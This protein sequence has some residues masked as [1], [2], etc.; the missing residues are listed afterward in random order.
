MHPRGRAHTPHR[1]CVTT[2]TIV[3]ARISV[4][5][6]GNTASFTG[7]LNYIKVYPKIVS[8]THTVQGREISQ[9]GTVYMLTTRKHMGYSGCTEDFAMNSVYVTATRNRRRRKQLVVVEITN[10]ITANA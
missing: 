9:E 5:V 1:H 4:C 3:G 10:L 7:P 8:T 6:C 2:A